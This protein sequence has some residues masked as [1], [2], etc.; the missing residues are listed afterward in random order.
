M[1]IVF[2]IVFIGLCAVISPAIAELA[3]QTQP[4][5]KLP[6]GEDTTYVAGPLDAEGYIDYQAALNERLGKGIA[7]DM[8]ANVL[9]WQ[10]LGPAPEGDAGMPAEFFQRLGMEKPPRDG[11]YLTG[12]WAYLRDHTNLK[13]RAIEAAFDATQRPWTAKD[14][15]HSAAWLK[16]NE[17]PLA[18]A[19]E[20]TRRP[21]Y[22]NPLISAAAEKG[23]GPM[24]G[25]LLPGV[26]KSRELASALVARAMLRVGEGKFDEAWQDLLACHRLGRL[27][28]RGGTLIEALVGIALDAI[29]SNADLAFLEPS[30]M[31]SQQ[32]KAC[33]H[34]LQGLPP[35]PPLA[36]K[37]D[38]AERFTYLDSLQSIR[39][40]GFAAL[41]D[42]L[43]MKNPYDAK[44]LEKV[45]WE[46]ALRAGNAWYDRLAAALRLP[47]RAE[48]KRAMDQIENDLRALKLETERAKLALGSGKD[49]PDKAAGK[50]L[51]ETLITLM[52]PSARKVTDAHDRAEQ[53]Q[54]NL[55]VAFALAAY[56]RDAGRYPAQLGD[57]APGYL[58]AVPDDLFAG[59]PLVYRPADA[60]YLLYSVG[61]NGKDEGG[62]WYDDV[63]PGDDLRVRMPLTEVSPPRRLTTPAA[64]P[65]QGSKIPWFLIAALCVLVAVAAAVLVLWRKRRRAP[66]PGRAADRTCPGCHPG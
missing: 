26:Q 44:A 55:H 17:A 37:I 30:D 22:F 16:A 28:A 31:T 18:V 50:V 47:G 52:M 5:P 15:P 43:G 33:L 11:A 34:D 32:I 62:R 61:S 19:V 4:K 24:V 51:G 38:L 3:A 41:G 6:V 40:G 12:L 57:L 54:R 21:L 27:V 10:A 59:K 53:I 66:Q 49:T 13:P 25:A 23:R 39:R 2:G 42:G 60:G 65:D 29:A 64:E 9:L 7:P 63:P 48:R 20:A 58:A 46:A 36:D 8:N 56:R 14:H 1:R 35:M 45:D